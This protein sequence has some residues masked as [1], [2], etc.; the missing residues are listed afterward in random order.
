MTTSAFAKYIPKAWP[1]QYAGTMR[2]GRI[3]G[4]TPT[5]SKVAEGWLRTKLGEQS[6]D[7]VRQQVAEVMLERGV[8]AEEAVELVNANR[9]LNGFK[10]DDNG[11]YIEGRHL[12]AAIKEAVSCAVAVGKLPSRGWGATN[13]G[14]KAFVAEHICVVEDKLPLGLMEPTGIAQR[15][16][17]THNGTGI[18]YEEYCDDVDIDFTIL[19]DHK[20]PEDQWAM[21]W[22]TGEQQGI[23]AT[24]SQGYGR[25]TVTKWETVRSPKS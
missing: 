17:H 20:F 22:L 6:D 8:A 3:A 24:R 12:K 2:V 5:D 16:V 23:G 13:K 7:I 25:Y 10:R 15:F 19:T 14:S 11:L 18:Q 1:Y 4:G 21:L 9:H